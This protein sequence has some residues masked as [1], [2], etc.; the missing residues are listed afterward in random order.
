MLKSFVYVDTD[1]GLGTPGAEIDDASALVLLMTGADLQL[2][3]AGSVLGNVPNA[4]TLVN[5]CR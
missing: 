4:D 1:I 3:G 2:L 5:L